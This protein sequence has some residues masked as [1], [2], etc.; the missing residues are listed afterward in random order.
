MNNE[1]KLHERSR[2]QCCQG[3]RKIFCNM[4]RGSNFRAIGENLFYWRY[5]VAVSAFLSIF[6]NIAFR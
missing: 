3:Q 1:R 4:S 2:Q 5:K 6:L